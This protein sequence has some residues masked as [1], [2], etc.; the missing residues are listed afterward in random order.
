MKVKIVSK[1]VVIAVSLGLGFLGFPAHSAISKVADTKVHSE[2]SE[3]ASTLGGYDARIHTS[4]ELF[5]PGTSQVNAS[6]TSTGDLH[7]ARYLHTATLLPDGKVLVVGGNGGTNIVLQADSV[8]LYDP[9]KHI[10]SVAFPLNKARLGHTATLLP[11]G[12]V[13]VTGGNTST[14]PPSFYPTSSA[15]LFDPATGTWAITGSLNTVRTNHTAT[16]LTNGKVLVTGGWDGSS[17]IASAELYDPETENWSSTGNLN[18]PRCMHT[19]TLLQSGK[20]LV[21]GGTDDGDLLVTLASAE[22]YDPGTST[23]SSTGRLGEP[24]VL[25]TATLLQ[26]GKVLV[27]G[28]YE[29]YLYGPSDREE[30]YEPIAGEWIHTGNL[31]TLRNGHSSTMLPDGRILVAGGRNSDILDSAELH[32]PA[33]GVWDRIEGLRTPRSDHTAT[34][35]ENGKVLVAGGWNGGPLSS[36]ELYD[37]NGPCAASLSPTTQS[38]DA[39]GGAAVVEVTAGD[40]SWTAESNVDWIHIT[41]ANSGSG[42][43]TV[44]FMVTPNNSTAARS[45]ELSIGGRVLKVTQAGLSVRII[46]ASAAGKKLFV[47][48]ENFDPG[49]VILLNGEEQATKNDPQNPR[50]SLIGKRAGKKIKPGDRLQVRNPNGSLSN[51]FIYTAGS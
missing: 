42:K 22:L 45:G 30:L 34:L 13:L 43:G 48:G 23:W 1:P 24:R 2:L 9:D 46:G 20:V 21:A 38:F 29:G 12:K 25:H 49:A 31:N 16:L 35:L 37:P 26:N 18:A 32:D 7:K 50:A 8:E 15:E 27:V 6:S 51:E 14:A 28:G 5:H 40:C 44:S 4:A 17:A 10:W 33:T 39:G 3:V 19:A 11:S 36:A 47:E 41:S